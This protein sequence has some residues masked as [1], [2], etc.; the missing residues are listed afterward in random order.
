MPNTTTTILQQLLHLLPRNDFRN[1]VGQHN[2]DKYTKKLSCWNQLTIM[3]YA[4]A[5]E[6]DSLREIETGLRIQDSRWYHLG[7]NTCARSTLSAA[8]SKRPCSIYESLF[9]KVLE[10]CQKLG[11]G[12]ASFSFRNDLYAIDASVIDL[13]LNLFPWAKFRKEKGAIKLHALFNIRSQIPELI[14]ITNGKVADITAIKNIDLS[15]YT[16]G[17]IFV[18]DKGYTDY[19]FF[20]KIKKAGHHFVTRL[21]EKA[22]IVHLG[23]H[24]KAFGRGVLRD[25]KIAFILKKAQEDY[26]DDLRLVTYHDEE[27]NVNYEFIT[28]ELRLS[29]SNIALIYKR[30][31]DVELFFKWIKQHLKIK[32]F[33]GTSKN[34]VLTQIWITM[35][36]Y[37]ILSWIK[38]QTKF[39]GSLHTL[40]V[41]FKELF[42]QP[43][44][45]IDI[46]N[47]TTKNLSKALPRGDPQLSLF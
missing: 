1:F 26:P 25:E 22:N 34:A 43:V 39:K 3:I 5:T 29:A 7:L 44:Q 6:K 32:T 11:S 40:T 16:K 36:Y 24:K 28:D 46:L 27:H 14:R 15:K 2:A 33:L 45:I 38:H 20:W 30:R 12:T 13:C 17:S 35:I 4:Q 9:Y 47:L 42:M 18:F 41:M 23:Q 21:K 37:L 31:W 10:R 19:S 8:N